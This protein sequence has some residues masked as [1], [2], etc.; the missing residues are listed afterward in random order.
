MESRALLF[1]SVRFIDDYMYVCFFKPTSRYY[2]SHFVGAVV[3]VGKGAVPS[4]KGEYGRY[5][6]QLVTVVATA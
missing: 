1:A 4:L 6:G 2:L 3:S 5:Q